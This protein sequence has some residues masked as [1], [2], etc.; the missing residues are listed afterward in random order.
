[1]GNKQQQ[2]I[3]HALIQ[4]GEIVNIPTITW[5]NT[6]HNSYVQRNSSTVNNH[7][8]VFLSI[9]LRLL[10]NTIATFYTQITYSHHHASSEFST[11]MLR[12][13]WSG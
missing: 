3:I 13:Q 9:F 5:A 11:T 1:M 2:L 6:L 12:Y 4:P 10:Y 8:S 7:N